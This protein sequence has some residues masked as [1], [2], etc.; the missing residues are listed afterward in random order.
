ML[1]QDILVN[2]ACKFSL[3]TWIEPNLVSVKRNKNS[4]HNIFPGFSLRRQ[5]GPVFKEVN[6]VAHSSRPSLMDQV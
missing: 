1:N 6:L 4:Q 3:F 5:N 2:I